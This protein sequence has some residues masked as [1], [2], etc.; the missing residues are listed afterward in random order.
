MPA[1]ALLPKAAATEVGATNARRSQPPPAKVATAPDT[2]SSL[3]RCWTRPRKSLL[4]AGSLLRISLVWSDRLRGVWSGVVGA[5]API[6]GE[7]STWLHAASEPAACGESQVEDQVE[8]DTQILG[9]VP[10]LGRCRRPRCRDARLGLAPVHLGL[11]NL[12]GHT[13]A[14]VKPG[15]VHP[16][17]VSRQV[18]HRWPA[19]RAHLHRFT[20]A[21]GLSLALAA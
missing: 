5:S 11:V 17:P 21:V 15:E 16:G 10:V 14:C 4:V 2:R 8:L 20:Q 12:T 1:W 3:P 13:T 7:P 18:R 9:E 6:S 19:P